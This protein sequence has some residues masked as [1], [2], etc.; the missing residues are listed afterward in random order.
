MKDNAYPRSPL[1]LTSPLHLPIKGK[2]S[3]YSNRGL[4]EFSYPLENVKNLEIFRFRKDGSRSHLF[5]TVTHHALL[6]VKVVGGWHYFF[7][8]AG[9]GDGSVK[10]WR[11]VHFHF[12]YCG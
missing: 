9:K 4:R 6:F 12:L 3:F 1:T 8:M 11:N 7:F 2:C 10:P 5:V